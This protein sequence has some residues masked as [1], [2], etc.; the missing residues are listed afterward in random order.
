MAKVRKAS[1]YPVA[2][3]DVTRHESVKLEGHALLEGGAEVSI[4]G[5]RGRFRFAEYVEG[6]TSDWLTVWGPVS[7]DGQRAQWRSFSP[8]KLRTVHRLRKAR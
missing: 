5:Q 4:K 7:G 6:P 3:V 1:S 2:P 8:G